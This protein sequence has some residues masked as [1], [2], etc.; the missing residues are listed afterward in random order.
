VWASAKERGRRPRREREREIGGAGREEGISMRLLLLDP[1][2]Y[3]T[4]LFIVLSRLIS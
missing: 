2:Y 4:S 3:I 1:N